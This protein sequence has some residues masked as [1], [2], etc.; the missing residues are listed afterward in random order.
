[1]VFSEKRYKDRLFDRLIGIEVPDKNS[2]SYDVDEVSDG[3]QGEGSQGNL[4]IIS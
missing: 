2:P 4:H 3:R 1:M